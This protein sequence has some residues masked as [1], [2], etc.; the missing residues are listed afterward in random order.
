MYRCSVC[1][2]VSVYG[3]NYD[4]T[5]RRSSI[6]KAFCFIIN[7]QPTFPFTTTTME[8]DMP[9]RRD[10]WDMGQRNAFQCNGSYT[11]LSINLFKF[12]RNCLEGMHIVR[13]YSFPFFVV[14]LLTVWHLLM[15][16]F[17][18]GS[19]LYSNNLEFFNFNFL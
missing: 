4:N 8:Y 3:K 14:V 17:A 7:L 18:V 16:P 1:V 9:T 10:T 15:L 5:R 12:N 13:I 2:C 11:S 6:I 19:L